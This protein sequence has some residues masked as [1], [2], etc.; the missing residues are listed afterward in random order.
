M[1]GHGPSSERQ[2]Q[3]DAQAQDHLQFVAVAAVK[4][5][6]SED[7]VPGAARESRIGRQFGADT[8]TGECKSTADAPG[9]IDKRGPVMCLAAA[10]TTENQ[11]K[12]CCGVVRGGAVASIKQ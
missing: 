5:E 9:I 12:G 8:D 11:T 3:E 7:P 1:R 2:G 4:Q 10:T 6:I